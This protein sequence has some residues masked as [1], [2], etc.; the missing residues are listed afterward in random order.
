MAAFHDH[1]SPIP[2]LSGE[3]RQSSFFSNTTYNTQTQAT[4]PGDLLAV[5]GNISHVRVMHSNF[6]RVPFFSN[7]SY[8]NLTLSVS[9]RD[10]VTANIVADL[11]PRRVKPPKT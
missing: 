3:P 2:A 10:A 7:T 8:N 6:P 5:L 11:P 4:Y 9:S 1:C